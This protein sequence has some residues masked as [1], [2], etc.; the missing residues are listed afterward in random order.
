MTSLYFLN[1]SNKSSG[2]CNQLNSLLS[3]I[4][5]CLNKEKIIV[6]DKFLKEINTDNYSPI[7]DIINLE[8]TNKFLEKYNIALIDG[9]F[10]YNLNIINAKYG[11]DNI[12]IDVTKKIK[13]FL[14]NN[15]FRI[16]KNINLNNLFQDCQP[17][18][19]KILKI[20]FILNNHNL[21]SMSFS[22]KN[23][24]LKNDINI[25]F[26][27]KNYTS[28]PSWDLIDSNEFIDITNDIYKNIFFNDCLIN[29]SNKFIDLINLDS[30]S[31]V[32]IIHLR[33]EED[34]IN[35]WSTINN[36]NKND[37]KIKLINKYIG[38]IN[39][40]INKE[41]K[42]IILTYSNENM[43]LDYLK[44]NNYNYYIQEKN[45]NNNREVNAIIDIINSK[46]CNNV[47]I[48]VGGSTFS[49]TISKLIKF[50]TIEWFDIN[51]L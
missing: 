32:N 28:A 38:L 34:A 7:S 10:T 14:N 45:K 48:A 44:N 2:L 51:K 26:N 36:I 17:N 19:E 13:Y 4:C 3:T 12:F 27:N 5:L 22:E 21:F 23:G 29:E 8:K 24:F 1:L 41:D 18:K 9:C 43:V 40:L 47:F 16:N 33:L 42:T 35:W 31:I 50:K 37:F 20:D 6:I 46:H 25:I 49:W 30:N 15:S 11:C 39:E